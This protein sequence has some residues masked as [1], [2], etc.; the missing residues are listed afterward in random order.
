MTDPSRWKLLSPA[1]SRALREYDQAGCVRLRNAQVRN[2]V[3]T[4]LYHYSDRRG[5][6]GIINA[7]QFWLTDYRHLNDDTEIRFG[8]DVAKVL[9]SECG[10]RGSKVKIFCDL[11]IDLLSAANLD[12]ALG[13]YIASFSCKRDDKLQWK[14]YGQDGHGFAIGLAPKLFTID[15]NPNRKPHENIF[16][17]PI[18]YGVSAC[19]V[20]HLPAIVSSVRIVADIIKRKAK[21]MADINK[22][23]PFFR[24]MANTLLARELIL[25]CLLVK[26]SAW[27]PEHEVRLF[28]PGQVANLA[29][30]VSTRSR[31]T[32]T[33]T[34]PFIKIDMLL[35]Q[36]GAIVEILIGPAASSDAE[37][38][39][40]SLI[41]PFHSNPRSIIRRSSLT[42]SY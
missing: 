21:A 30:H 2:A 7:R 10:M 31:G 20:L 41:A 4:P 8:I 12:T 25:N 23:M 33:V 27:A 22:G 35:E 9:L 19:R 11:T 26:N 3:I 18:S 24:E 28:V 32:E 40:C 5:F 14:K 29:P 16:V 34:V 39:A 17:S 1:F 38:F 13:F 36:P 42:Q 37:D 15:D 6:E